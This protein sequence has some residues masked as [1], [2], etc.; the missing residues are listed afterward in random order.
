M[1]KNGQENGSGEYLTLVFDNCG[2]QNKNH[3]VL[4]YLLYLVEKKVYK[5]VEAVF[6]VAGHTKNVCDRLFKQLKRGFHYKN[7]YT[8]N[9]LIRVCN[10]SD[11][12]TPIHCSSNNFF[13]WDLYLDRI[14]KRPAAGTVNKNHIFK[15]VQTKPGILITEIIKDE[16]VKE[17]NL[18]KLSKNATGGQ[19]SS[20]TRIINYGKKIKRRRGLGCVRLNKLI[21]MRSGDH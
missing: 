21:F 11:S 17:Q 2:G 5:T 18:I 1:P 16:D 19:K 14:Y 6:L 10:I 13:D 3:M 15:S 12:I 8:M 4:R 9:Q 7:V 20:R